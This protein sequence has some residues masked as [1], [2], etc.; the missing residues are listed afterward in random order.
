[1]RKLLLVIGRL[2]LEAVVFYVAAIL[3]ML[4]FAFGSEWARFGGLLLIVV[5]SE[6]RYIR[7]AIEKAKTGSKWLK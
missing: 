7:P 1:M 6:R 5:M 2:S 3:M 4:V